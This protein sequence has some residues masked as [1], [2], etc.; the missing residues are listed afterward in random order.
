MRAAGDGKRA[1]IA[2]ADWASK[3]PP[4]ASPTARPSRQPRKR[5]DRGGGVMADGGLG[6]GATALYAPPSPW[7]GGTDLLE[8][9][10]SAVS[11]S[12]PVPVRAK[13]NV[14]LW[15]TARPLDGLP[16]PSK[17]PPVLAPR[18]KYPNGAPLTP[19]WKGAE[20]SREKLG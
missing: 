6:W 15:P 20:P 5:S 17:L 8:K 11:P 18:S 1:R 3:R 2:S 13:V 7:P 16:P 9:N 4:R 12:S 19:S 10:D 14:P